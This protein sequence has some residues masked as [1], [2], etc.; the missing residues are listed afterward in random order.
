MIE[1]SPVP[2]RRLAPLLVVGV[3]W[4]TLAA[5]A[6]AAGLVV[7]PATEPPLRIGLAAGLPVLGVGVALLVLPRFRAWAGSLDLA[8]LINLQGWRVAGFAFLALYAQGLLPG[9]FAWP[10]GL[11]DIAVGIA[12]PFVAG[13][14]VRR[15]RAAGRVV[16]G[17]TAFGIADFV[18]AIA[19]GMANHLTVLPAVPDGAATH[20]PMAELPLSLI[21]TFV[22]PFLLVVHLLTLARLR[23]GGH[24]PGRGGSRSTAQD[25]RGG[26]RC[27]H[28]LR[29]R[30][31]SAGRV[32]GPSAAPPSSAV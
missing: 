29:V 22:V 30:G 1:S 23:A 20:A 24:H 5:V 8:L 25:S 21:P 11:G 17:W 2:L 10:A 28:Q 12:A 31:S 3:V 9:G 15:G 7:R 16:A 32:Q 19:L 6:A 26:D 4:L 13:H 27:H 18:V 14:V